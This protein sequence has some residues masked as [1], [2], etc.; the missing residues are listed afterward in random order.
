MPSDEVDDPRGVRT[1]GQERGRQGHQHEA[2]QEHCGAAGAGAAQE[3]GDGHDR[4]S[5]V[6]FGHL[7]VMDAMWVF[8]CACAYLF[9]LALT[10]RARSFGTRFKGSALHPRALFQDLLCWLT[11]EK[12]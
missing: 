5:N 10:Q 12:A 2:D 4:L 7:G 6:E 1:R 9:A 8:V 3:D 11:H